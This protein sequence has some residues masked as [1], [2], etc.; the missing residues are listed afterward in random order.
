MSNTQKMI[1]KRVLVTGAGTGIGRGVALEFANEGAAVVLHYA[2]SGDGALSA[3]AQI[4][5]GGGN[6]QAFQADLG[7]IGQVQELAAKAADF[8][9]GIDIL[10][11][12]AGITMN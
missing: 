9:G 6:A 3:V 7:D 11:N 4:H 8:L 12:N 2:H 5:A 10:V 1:G